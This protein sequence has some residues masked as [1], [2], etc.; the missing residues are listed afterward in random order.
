MR[1][2]GLTIG[3]VILAT[4]LVVVGYGLYGMLA[5]TIALEGPWAT[6]G[7]IAVVCASLVALAVAALFILDDWHGQG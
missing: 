4:T 3:A 5:A 1:L 7:G 2:A 6:A